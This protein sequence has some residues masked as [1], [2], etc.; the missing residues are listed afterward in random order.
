MAAWSLLKGADVPLKEADFSGKL[1]I[2][3]GVHNFKIFWQIAFIG[4]WCGAMDDARDAFTF[5][6]E[7][8]MYI[9][10]EFIKPII[11]NISFFEEDTKDYYISVCQYLFYTI[12]AWQNI[13]SISEINLLHEYNDKLKK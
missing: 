12:T 7:H 4:G 9:P 13:T 6:L 8:P 11:S 1:F 10:E 5:M 3:E 2:D